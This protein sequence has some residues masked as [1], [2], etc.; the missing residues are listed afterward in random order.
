MSKIDNIAFGEYIRNLRES[1][2]LP[3][4]KV[5]TLPSRTNRHTIQYLAKRV[6]VSTHNQND[7]Q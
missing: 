7:K 4:R 2:N 5:A 1:E 6:S 3:L